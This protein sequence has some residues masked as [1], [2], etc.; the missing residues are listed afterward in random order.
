MMLFSTETGEAKCLLQDEGILTDHRT[1]IA[2]AIVAKY[3]AP[4]VVSAIGVVGTGI[5]ARLQVKRVS[6]VSIV[7][8]VIDPS[9]PQP[10]KAVVHHPPPHKAGGAKSQRFSMRV[11]SDLVRNPTANCYDWSR[12]RTSG[13][14]SIG[15]VQVLQTWGGF[16]I[17][18]TRFC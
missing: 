9:P 4:A 10:R 15:F 2:G 12:W 16:E 14:S 17:E 6:Q 11:C 1:A 18:F 8:P 3:F 13:S 5:Q 7:S